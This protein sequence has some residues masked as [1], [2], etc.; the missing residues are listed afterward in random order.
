M[1]IKN[2]KLA[3][4]SILSVIVLLATGCKIN[5]CEKYY[6]ASF[7]INMYANS[8]TISIGDTISLKV[9]F[10]RAMVN[11]APSDDFILTDDFI[12]HELNIALLDHDSMR[13]NISNSTAANSLFDIVN[14]VGNFGDTYGNSLLKINYQT[15]NDS[16]IVDLQL[17]AKKTGVFVFMFIDFAASRHT[18]TISN[19]DNLTLGHPD[20]TEF[21][22]HGLFINRNTNTNYYL[23]QDH[24]AYIET[25]INTY[26]DPDNWDKNAANDRQHDLEFGSFSVVVK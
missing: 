19:H 5:N 8:D 17:I 13:L 22:W 21:Y 16:A 7:P 12:D 25:T 15:T 3:A 2:N 23:I 10:S 14:N 6:Q 18:P 4:L 20:C 11:Q 24:N 26:L 9:R 1:T